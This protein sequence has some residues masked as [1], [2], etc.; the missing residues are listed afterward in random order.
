MVGKKAP[1]KD[2]G[3]KAEFKL[4]SPNFGNGQELPLDMRWGEDNVWVRLSSGCVAMPFVWD[5][6]PGADYGAG[7][8]GDGGAE[9]A[10]L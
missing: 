10:A 5:H 7:G 6:A 8:D 2:K 1:K 4:W 9:G 3:P